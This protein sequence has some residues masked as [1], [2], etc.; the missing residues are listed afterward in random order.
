[1][2]V[3]GGPTRG[4]G[5]EVRNSCSLLFRRTVVLELTDIMQRTTIMISSRTE[6]SGHS[7]KHH[8]ERASGEV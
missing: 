7:D 1:M 2:G 3:V 6:I 4:K 8:R 5:F